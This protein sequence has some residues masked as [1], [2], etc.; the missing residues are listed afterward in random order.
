MFGCFFTVFRIVAS[1]ILGLVVFF[2]V[3]GFQ[4]TDNLRRPF[5]TTEFY[6][7]HLSDNDAYNRI[8]DEVL[9]DPEFEDTTDDL[10]GDLDFTRE[11]VA[12]THADIAGV[13]REIIPPD[14]LQSQVEGAIQGA[15]EYLNKET[16]EPEVFIELGPPLERAKSTLFAYMDRR[17]DEL[18]DKPVTTMEELRDELESL[19]REMEDGKIPERVPFIEDP[20]ALVQ[21]YV[22][23]TIAGLEEVPATTTEEFR[24][25]LEKVYQELANGRLPT[26]IPSIE[27]IPVADRLAA[28]DLAWEIVSKDPTFPKEAIEGLREQA[29]SI[30]DQLRQGSIVGA[31]EVAS[32][33]LTRP[34]VEKFIDDGYDLA[35]KRLQEDQSFPRE[36]LDGLAQRA[37]AIKAHLGAGEIKD[38]L[39]LGARGLAEPLIDDALDDLRQELDEEDRLDLVTI[40]AKQNNQTKEE[41]LDDLDPFRDVIDASAVGRLLAILMIVLGTVFMVVVHL[42]H[43]SSGLRWPGITLLLSGLVFLIVGIVLNSV[44]TDRFDDWLGRG[45]SAVSPIPPT[46]ITITSDVLTSMASDVSR[47]FIVASVVIMVVGSVF[48]VASVV[49]RMLHIPFISR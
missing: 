21:S 23:E 17:I 46:M 41:F 9:L 19:Y 6:T 2:G 29:E 4:L 42:P 12:V 25:E 20:D 47:G 34:A 30:K 26:R 1:F 3:F 40:A 14:Y 28:F 33:P 45:V 18:E 24:A 43:L 11:D 15:I 48:I 31:L 13:A 8:Y 35:F 22:D 27:A 38:A 49:I 37:D 10:L 44:L 16:D 32:D 5:L 7:D 39:K 36:A